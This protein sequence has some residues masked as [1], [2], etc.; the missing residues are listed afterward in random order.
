MLNPIACQNCGT[1]C[2]TTGQ[3]NLAARDFTDLRNGSYNLCRACL[4]GWHDAKGRV[5]S[6]VRHTNRLAYLA[7]TA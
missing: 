3:V 6:Y 5:L 1:D 7:I 2:L 4:P